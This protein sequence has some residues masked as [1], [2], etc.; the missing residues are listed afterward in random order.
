MPMHHPQATRSPQRC[1]ACTSP[2]SASC[3]L[4]SHSSTCHNAG[5]CGHNFD[6]T[7][8]VCREWDGD[9][10]VSYRWGWA[11]LQCAV[12]M[13]T[14]MAKSEP[15]S[16][17]PRL[18]ACGRAPRSLTAAV[19]TYMSVKLPPVLELEGLIADG[20]LR[21]LRAWGSR[22]VGADWAPDGS[23]VTRRKIRPRRSA[24]CTRVLA[25]LLHHASPVDP[26]TR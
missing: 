8:S 23:S 22:G 25:S 7:L 21:E 1:L 9:E 17:T 19:R 10:A 2:E 5:V 26:P 20:G 13:V 4:K 24:A 18:L 3:R 15:A 11:P 16:T 6:T 14:T 12:S